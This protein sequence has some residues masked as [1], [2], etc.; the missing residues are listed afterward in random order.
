MSKRDERGAPRLYKRGIVDFAIDKLGGLTVVARNIDV[1]VTTVSSW[2]RRNKVSVLGL[3]QLK[4]A[5]RLPDT[6]L[7]ALNATVSH[8]YAK[9]ISYEVS[10]KSWGWKR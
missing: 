7:V 3:K 8:L 1:K 10:C 9:K 5:Y 4:A 2:M 6:K